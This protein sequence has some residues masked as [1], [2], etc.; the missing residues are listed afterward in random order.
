MHRNLSASNIA[1][2]LAGIVF[3]FVFPHL[4]LIPIPFVYTL[5][6]LLLVW[7]LLRR[8]NEN[9]AD[10]GFSFK[11]FESKAIFL[12]ALA[13]ILL[14]I[15]LNYFLFPLLSKI[16]FL[17]K[18]NLDDFSFIRHQFV[19][20]LFILV[21][22]WVVGGWYEELV[23]HGYVFTRFEKIVPG[24]YATVI[25]FLLTNIIFGL[26]HV[27]LG[28]SGMLNAFFAGCAYH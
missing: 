15:F 8:T 25:S 14:F 21:M 20:Y 24:K 26:Y 5:P 2:S 11:R 18:A 4:G 27:Q 7:L 6:V 9:F 10:L 13:A 23:F 16:I 3:I 19:N 1:L 12:G 22:G 28:T 17:P